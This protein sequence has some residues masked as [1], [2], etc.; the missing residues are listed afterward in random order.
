V[1]DALLQSVA[2]VVLR[3]GEVLVV[4]HALRRLLELPG[5]RVG[6]LWAPGEVESDAGALARILRKEAS[7]TLRSV[8][9][10]LGRDANDDWECRFYLCECDGAPAAGNGTTEAFFSGAE[11]LHA[12]MWA[13]DEA[14]AYEAISRVSL[15]AF[16]S[17]LSGAAVK[18]A[19]QAARRRVID[20]ER[21][22]R[23]NAGRKAT[24]P[25]PGSDP[26]TPDVEALAQVRR[27][28]DGLAMLRLRGALGHFLPDPPPVLH[29]PAALRMEPIPLPRLPEMPRPAARRPGA[30]L[31]LLLALVAAL[32]TNVPVD[33]FGRS[34]GPARSWSEAAL[35][36]GRGLR[37]RALEILRRLAS[38]QS[39]AVSV[40]CVVRP[41]D[42]VT[43]WEG[44][45]T[46]GLLAA[47]EEGDANSGIVATAAMM[48]LV[49]SAHAEGVAI[50][51]APPAV[52]SF[53]APP[54]VMVCE[55][56]GSIITFFWVVVPGA[57]ADVEAA[58]T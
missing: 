19:R 39:G 51:T 8:L 18:R 27:L 45:K 31:G 36:L 46:R 43:R 12:G 1:A 33:G 9:C 49:L 24:R 15:G 47:D 38:D 34:V 21:R 28:N 26:P 3:R 54:Q 48:D 22:L 16:G 29:P 11:I 40:L 4:R 50:V 35:W 37:A 20:E 23:A 52:G 6:G 25:P 55:V 2:A 42:G 13:A 14:M 58:T 41:G 32:D 56:I 53:L 17:A 57:E 5:G 7:L 30:S 44:M 10:C